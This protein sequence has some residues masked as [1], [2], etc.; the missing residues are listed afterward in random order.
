MYV[1]I[2]MLYVLN[3][4]DN[5]RLAAFCGVGLDYVKTYNLEKLN[6]PSKEN[7][8]AICTLKNHLGICLARA[9]RIK[10]AIEL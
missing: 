7:I 8:H 3:G 9:G 10:E 2:T 1:M 6:K 5:Q 4:T